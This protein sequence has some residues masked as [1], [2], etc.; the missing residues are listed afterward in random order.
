MSI[1]GPHL[2]KSIYTICR[3]TYLLWLPC[4]D[5]F[6]I[7]ISVD[8]WNWKSD[9]KLC[10]YQ[11]ICTVTSE[12]VKILFSVDEYCSIVTSKTGFPRE[13]RW[14]IVLRKFSD[15]GCVSRFSHVTKETTYVNRFLVWG[16]KYD[17]D[18]FFLFTSSSSVRWK[19]SNFHERL[20]WSTPTLWSI[21][22]PRRAESR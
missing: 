9:L 3:F 2:D 4:F 18:I 14:L 12:K 5:I 11:F 21:G 13:G 20:G 7:F 8:I 10:T 6:Y 1:L 22:V 17:A 19:V 15:Q 16:P